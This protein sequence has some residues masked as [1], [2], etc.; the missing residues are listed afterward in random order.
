MAIGEQ[1]SV[2]VVRVRPRV[3]PALG[4]DAVDAGL[5]RRGHRRAAAG[6]VAKWAEQWV[7]AARGGAQAEHRTAVS[8][9]EG[10]VLLAHSLGQRTQ[11]AAR[12]ELEHRGL[13]VREARTEAESAPRDRLHG[14]HG[15]V[16]L[17]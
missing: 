8:Q 16:H 12:R 4:A 13:Q 6:P 3:E 11:R 2:D 14:S 17:G 7:S 9:R 10:L 15:V 5:A 1:R